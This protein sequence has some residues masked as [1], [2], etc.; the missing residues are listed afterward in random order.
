MNTPKQKTPRSINITTCIASVIENRAREI[1]LACIFFPSFAV[2]LTQFV[3]NTTYLF[4]ISSLYTWD[5]V[6]IVMSKTA[7]KSPLSKRI[8]EQLLNIPL[9]CIA[10]KQFDEIKGSGIYSSC[11]NSIHDIE[12]ESKY[13]SMAALAGLISHIEHMQNIKIYIENLS[14]NFSYLD[15]LFLV[16]YFT[17]RALELVAPING[18][19]K[20]S[21]SGYFHCRTAEGG[22]LLRSSLLQ[23]FRDLHT[24]QKRHEAIAALLKPSGLKLELKTCLENF[25]NTEIVTGRLLQTPSH[26]QAYVK[27][28]VITALLMRNAL[29]QAQTLKNVLLKYSPE[30]EL[31][32]SLI[33]CLD[34]RRA[35][36]LLNDLSGFI[37]PGIAV[38]KKISNSE[39][40]YAIK[41]G[42]DSMLDTSRKIFKVALE[43][44]HSLFNEYK[45]KITENGI[46]LLYNEPR[47]YYIQCENFNCSEKKHLLGEEIVK[48]NIKY[49]K[50]T[51][52]TPSLITLSENIISV[53]TEI[54]TLSL[55]RVEVI[56]ERARSSILCLYNISHAVSLIDI[57][58]S[59]AAFSEENCCTVPILDSNIIHIEEGKH[60]F[61]EDDCIPVNFTMNPFSN[62]QII[63]GPNSSGKT[64]YL[65]TLG[66]LTILAY[67]GCL[68]PAKIVQLP[69]FDQIFSVI[70]D[71][72]SLEHN[73]SSFLSSM[74][75]FS[76]LLENS[77]ENSLVIIDEIGRGTSYED[78]LSLAWSLIETLVDVGCFALSTTHFSQLVE[79]ESL[80]TS[81]KNIH[82]EVFSMHE[83]PICE[84]KDYGLRLAGA[85][86]LPG[87]IVKTAYEM[88]EQ[89]GR[90]LNLML[91]NGGLR[92][93]QEKSSIRIIDQ[94]LKLKNE[95]PQDMLVE[96]LL[97]FQKRLF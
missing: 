8:K 53:K 89:I 15:S 85:S 35:D 17:A 29:Y 34:D 6:E 1:G 91:S 16:D 90:T 13:V 88:S 40:L 10:R 30:S 76:Y 44:V 87:D 78:G 82:M 80:Y 50:T 47:G 28:Q 48:I 22:R 74:Q 31:I 12:V 63:T 20:K 83:G 77:T 25:P 21:V 68:V 94:L 27:N 41:P 73:S 49:N 92:V 81:V 79:L 39:C 9:S 52:S 5:P 3:D 23:P 11:V 75:Q 70:G 36:S 55:S 51:F 58:L 97:E 43:K 19:S 45:Q 67:S 64:T 72:E 7:E 56:L 32:L 54:L 18:N 57:L 38:K 2:S 95:S 66:V 96:N 46:K 62:T 59:F 33:E 61:L 71:M 69:L 42:L 84:E 93:N 14:I 4:T 26:S 24:I 60:P 37:D 86:A 65:K